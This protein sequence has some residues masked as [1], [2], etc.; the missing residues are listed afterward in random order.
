MAIAYA[1]ADDAASADADA[2]VVPD[3]VIPPKITIAPQ[4]EQAIAK[5]GPDGRLL[6]G[7]KALNAGGRPKKLREIEYMLNKEHRNLQNM[8]V[9]FQRLKALAM[10]ETI[11]VPYFTEQG[12]I[13]LKCELKAD[14]RFMELYLKRVLGPE[15]SFDDSIDLSDAPPE[16]LE[17]LNRVLAR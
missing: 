6:P 11:I 7:T 2:S 8:R 12:E 9:I 3:E 13:A 4:K 14:A 15:K 1:N 16:V 10:G 17:Y 5:R